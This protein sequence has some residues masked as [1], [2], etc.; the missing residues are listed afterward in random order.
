MHDNFS[1]SEQLERAARAGDE[2]A[3]IELASQLLERQNDPAGRQRGI[4]LLE[5]AAVGPQAPAAQWVLGGFHLQNAS[6]SGALTQARHWLELAADA[7]VGPAMDRLANMHL[8]GIGTEYAPQTALSLLQKLAEAGFQHAAWEIGYLRSTLPELLDATAA[9]MAFARACALGYPPA[10]YSLG[11]RFATGAG[12]ESDPAFARALLL[13]AA[14]ARLPDA[15]AA[16]DELAGNAPAD[17][18]DDW[19]RAL[20]QNRAAAA[21]LLQRLAQ[22]S[23]TISPASTGDTAALEAHFAALG[24]PALAIGENGRLGVTR[25]DGAALHAVRAPWDWVSRQPRIAISAGFLSR[26]ERARMLAM[27]GENL[28]VPGD[29]TT[30]TVHGG[31][32]RR[33]FD[34]SGKAFGA[35]MSDAVIRCIER[36]IAEA[37]GCEIAAIEPCSVIRYQ[38]G[39]QYRPHVDYFSDQQLAENKRTG[40]DHG[41]QRIATFLVCLQAAG[42]GGATRYPRAGIDIEHRPGQAVLHYNTRPDGR[43]DEASLHHGTPVTEGEKWLLRTTLRAGSRYPRAEPAP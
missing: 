19:Y 35:L 14:D 3:R 43:A 40:T 33:F 26:E 22:S 5:Q 21:G 29:Y 36:R 20:K 32:E 42:A 13:R 30:G 23:I 37:A 41:G 24:H 8:R 18:V 11:L 12:V 7:A 17:T 2:M 38:P 31:A 10:Y 15:L 34:G 28:L 25:P 9:V 39:Q 6:T 16:A 4:D 1:A 27:A